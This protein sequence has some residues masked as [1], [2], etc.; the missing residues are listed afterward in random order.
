MKQSAENILWHTQR[1]LYL[2]FITQMK[3][4]ANFF[5]QN[6]INFCFQGTAVVDMMMCSS[7]HKVYCKFKLK[8]SYKSVVPVYNNP[9][10][11]HHNVT[12]D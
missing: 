6:V 1:T 4:I 12:L 5:F 7:A 11:Y 3:A 8:K 2:L 9:I 10:S